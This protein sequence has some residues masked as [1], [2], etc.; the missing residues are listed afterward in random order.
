MNIQQIF[1]H[2]SRYKSRGEYVP[3]A[4]VLHEINEPLAAVDARAGTN[5]INALKPTAHQSYHYVLDGAVVHSYVDPDNAARALGD[6]E[7][8][9]GWDVQTAFP[10]LDPDLY[11]VNIGVVI[12]GSNL[13]D[14][15]CI[16]CCGRAYAPAMMD[17]LQRLIHALVTLYSI[18][19]SSSRLWLHNDELCDLCID[20]LRLPPVD[21]GVGQEDW[22]CDRLAEMPEGDAENPMLV[23]TDCHAYPMP[24]S[25]CDTL[26]ALPPA[27]GT[28]IM[29]V[30]TDCNAYPSYIVVKDG[31]CL[32]LADL[33]TPG[34][35][36]LPEL[37]GNDCAVYTPQ[38]IVCN[39][40]GALSERPATSPA[41]CHEQVVTPD[42][43]TIPLD[44]GDWE[45]YHD[46]VTGACMTGRQTPFNNAASGE[47]AIA[48]GY[49]TIASGLDSHAEGQTTEALGTAAHAEGY[50]TIA[51]GGPSHAEGRGTQATAGSAHAE[52]RDTIASGAAAHSEGIG[53]TASGIYSHSEGSGSIASGQFSHAEGHDTTASGSGSHAE[54][55]DTLAS[56]LDSHAQNRETEALAQY[57]SAIGYQSRALVNAEVAEAN[58]MFEVPG[59]AQKRT[60]HW[61]LDSI[62]QDPNSYVPML[63]RGDVADLSVSPGTAQNWTF[64][65]VGTTADNSHVWMFNIDA[66]ISNPSSVTVL[67]Q[68][69]QTLF[70]SDSQYSI[71]IVPDAVN[72][73]FKLRVY[74]GATAGNYHIRWYAFGH[75]AQIIF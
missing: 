31:I 4:I 51:S 74:K 55:E 35:D 62:V 61:Q 54:G 65:I 58:G 1:T 75:A 23:G 21:P 73:T 66:A 33:T 72:G 7:T 37:I 57:S 32:A 10:G 63:I 41:M 44:D 3:V 48:E 36:P 5:L 6:T 38:D 30:G 22:L 46:P 42:C 19:V 53:T 49:A 39:A 68:T 34:S 25:L 2:A 27:I 29:L 12:G 26:A 15:Q 56:G 14:N 11:T 67:A 43:K 47:H 18:D 13:G 28:D 69:L 20:D 17:A 70:S 9:T 8:L 16:P 64:Q 71:D 50:E 40:L 60:I 45:I 59:D 24:A 52:G